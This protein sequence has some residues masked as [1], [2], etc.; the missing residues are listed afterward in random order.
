M[1]LQIKFP[2]WAMLYNYIH[3]C[4]QAHCSGIGMI[5]PGRRIHSFSRGRC[6]DQKSLSSRLNCRSASCD[7][8]SRVIT[9]TGVTLTDGADNSIFFRTSAGPIE[10]P[11]SQVPH[12]GHPFQLCCASFLLGP[13]FELSPGSCECRNKSAVLNGPDNRTVIM[14]SG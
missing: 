10:A 7:R 11:H 4:T 9:T 13:A 5:Y 1:C 6:Y 3:N 14:R 12:S 2:W 8:V